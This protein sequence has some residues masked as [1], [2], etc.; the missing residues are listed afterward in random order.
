VRSAGVR[1]GRWTLSLLLLWLFAPSL[2]A[3]A[4][5]LH[6]DLTD[7]PRNLYHARL[8]IPPTPVKSRWSSPNGFLEITV[9]ADRSVR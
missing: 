5:R 7:A 3:Q 8:R 4:I 1:L 6:V 2:S 9:P